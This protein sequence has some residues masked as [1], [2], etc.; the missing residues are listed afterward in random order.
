MRE[1]QIQSAIIKE[2]EK[3]GAY[4][5]KTIQCSKA[6]VPDILMCY[7]GRFIGVE[8]KKHGGRASKLQEY[9]V[10]KIKEA[11]GVSGI[12]YSVDEAMEL[13]ESI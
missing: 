3:L 11:N 12:V 1:Q 13:L 8:V 4:V 2:A 7:K 10:K 9:H 6:G 5:V